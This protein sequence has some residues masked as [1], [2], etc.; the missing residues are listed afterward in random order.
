MNTTTKKDL[1]HQ[2]A[3][4]AESP[5][6]LA[7][8]AID[9]LFIHLRDQLIVGHRIEVRGFGTLSVRSTVAKPTAHNPRTGEQ[10]FVPARRKVHFKP[11]KQ[12]KQSLSVAGE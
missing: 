5:K 11:G 8:E 4:R 3:Q 10:V 2:V 6:G 7:L 9:A 1:A 12:I